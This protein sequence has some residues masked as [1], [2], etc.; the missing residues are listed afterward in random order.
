[1]VAEVPPRPWLPLLRQKPPFTGLM[2]LM[3]AVLVSG[4]VCYVLAGYLTSD[5]RRL[6]AA[7]QQLA[8]GDLSARARVLS[9][10]EIGVVASAFN[11]MAANLQ[12]RVGELDQLNRHLTH[13]VGERERN[14]R[15]CG[16]SEG[17]PPSSAR[18]M[19]SGVKSSRPRLARVLPWRR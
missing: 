4:I 7:T 5:V 8:A 1:M 18:R 12:M 17:S 2:I 15:A 6:R 19:S 13:E 3:I 16:R 14:A 9:R 11:E 10:D